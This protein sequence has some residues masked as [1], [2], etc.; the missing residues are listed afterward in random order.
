[1]V[2]LLSGWQT[3]RD[4]FNFDENVGYVFNQVFGKDNYKLIYQLL[5]TDC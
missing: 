3:V 4:Y 2:G 5:A 1:M